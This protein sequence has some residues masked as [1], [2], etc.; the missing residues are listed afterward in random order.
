VRRLATTHDPFRW[1]AAELVGEPR[2]EP[3][4][5]LGLD[6]G[7]PDSL[8]YAASTRFE[9]QLPPVKTGESVL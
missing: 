7:A 9:I 2:L 6:V 1:E 4:M 8:L 3:L 5:A